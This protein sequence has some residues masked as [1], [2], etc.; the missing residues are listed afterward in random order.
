MDW[1]FEVAKGDDLSKLITDGF[2]PIADQQHWLSLSGAGSGDLQIGLETY[3]PSHSGDFASMSYGDGYDSGG[4]YYDPGYPGDGGGGG[5]GPDPADPPPPASFDPDQPIGPLFDYSTLID[6]SV[7]TSWFEALNGYAD[8]PVGSWHDYDSLEQYL[9]GE[10]LFDLD[11]ELIDLSSY[12]RGYGSAYVEYD[13]YTPIVHFGVPGG[14]GLVP[15]FSEWTEVSDLGIIGDDGLSSFEVTHH[16]TFMGFQRAQTYQVASLDDPFDFLGRVSGVLDALDLQQAWEDFEEGMNGQPNTQ[17]MGTPSISMA[18]GML[19]APV[20]L[21]GVLVGHV[22]VNDQ[23]MRLYDANGNLLP[24]RTILPQSWHQLDGVLF[25]E[26]MAHQER[27]MGVPFAQSIVTFAGV[28]AGGLLGLG[29]WQG[30][31]FGFASDVISGG[32]AATATA[33]ARL[34]E[35]AYELRAFDLRNRSQ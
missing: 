17:A 23:G 24:G 5:G 14:S 7:F 31:G 22:M 4:G 10:W 9:N 1:E 28:A 35:A 6:D 3:A 26:Q 27:T 20:T 8:P 19:M 21:G 11:P 13:Q 16:T 12:D 30:L 33:Y 15:I 29:F 34:L 25:E 32:S 2:S 18:N